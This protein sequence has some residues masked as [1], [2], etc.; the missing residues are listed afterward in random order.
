VDTNFIKFFLLTFSMGLVNNLGYSMFLTGSQILADRFH[1]ANLM[2]LV[3]FMLVGFD[4]F[5][6]CANVRWFL[7]IPH[8]IRFLMVT[9]MNVTAYVLCP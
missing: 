3:T 2:P 5:I 1:Y 9:A 7:H 4:I 6:Q 8:I